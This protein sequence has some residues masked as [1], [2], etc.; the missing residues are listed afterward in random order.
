MN[1]HSA[2]R[3]SPGIRLE[4][5][6]LQMVS[7]EGSQ[8]L[9]DLLQRFDD[10]KKKLENGTV[11][12]FTSLTAV[13]APV[14]LSSAE[15]QIRGEATAGYLKSKSAHSY[16]SLIGTDL[17]R[18]AGIPRTSPSIFAPMSQIRPAVQPAPHSMTMTKE[19]VL[20]HWKNFVNN[21][22]QEKIAVGT[23]LREAQIMDVNN[24]FLR[25]ACTD[26][27][28]FSSLKRHKEFLSEKFRQVSGKHVVVEPVLH[29]HSDAVSKRKKNAGCRAGGKNRKKRSTSGSRTSR[30]S[31][32]KTGTRRRTHGVTLDF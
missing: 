10:L 3:R 14:P 6:L 11:P 30:A 4:A 20:E 1:N 25:I 17:A 15:L 21:V 8:N 26:D 28:S 13:Q 5:A 16:S 12:S 27:Y 2:G 19:D 7:M 32:F 31:A 23:S 9:T 18:L 24:G 29:A 22:A